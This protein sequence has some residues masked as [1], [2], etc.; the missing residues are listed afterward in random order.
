MRPVNVSPRQENIEKLLKVLECDLEDLFCSGEEKTEA[1]LRK[2][3]TQKLKSAKLAD[4]NYFNKM[5][6]AYFESKI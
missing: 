4:L 2:E 1:Q 3:I 6:K 5:L